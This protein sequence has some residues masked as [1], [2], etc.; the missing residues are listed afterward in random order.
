[1]DPILSRMYHLIL[2]GWTASS[3]EPDLQPYFIC[4]DELSVIDDCVL[5]GSRVVMSPPG[6]DIVLNQL[7][8]TH[9]G[10]KMKSLAHSYVWWPKLDADIVSKVQ[11]CEICCLSPSKAPLHPWEWPT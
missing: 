2:H 10:I 1:M 7:Y 5:W 6:H 9:P 8:H 3:S 11:R 4:K